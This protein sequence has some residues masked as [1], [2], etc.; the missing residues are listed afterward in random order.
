[1]ILNNDAFLSFQVEDQE[2]ATLYRASAGHPAAVIA[3]IRSVFWK[4]GIIGGDRIVCDMQGVPTLLIAKEGEKALTAS[5]PALAF[6]HYISTPSA[7]ARQQPRGVGKYHYLINEVRDDA[8][9]GLRIRWRHNGSPQW[10][11]AVAAESPA[12][13][14]EALRQLAKPYLY[15]IGDGEEGSSEDSFIDIP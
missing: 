5:Y 2:F 9:G 4:G 11:H 15:K 8:Q 13:A 6:R 1:M 12:L 10:F 7:R 14:A 3:D